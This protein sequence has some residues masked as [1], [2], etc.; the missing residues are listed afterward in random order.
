M[1]ADEAPTPEEMSPL[2]RRCSR[3]ELADGIKMTVLTVAEVGV[4]VEIE[5]AT[6]QVQQPSTESC[7]VYFQWPVRQTGWCGLPVEERP[8]LSTIWDRAEAYSLA[9]PAFFFCLGAVFTTIYFA[10]DEALQST[11]SWMRPPDMDT[12]LTLLTTFAATALL[13]V[14]GMYPIG[15]LTWYGGVSVAITRKISHIIFITLLPLT[16]V[17]LNE[18]EEG[19]ARDMYLAMVW[20]SLSSTLLL[21]I[22]FSKASRKYVPLLRIAFAGIERSDDRPHAL[23]WFSLQMVGQTLVQIPMIQW[24][25]QDERGLLI[26]IPFL[27]VG[28]GDGLAEPVGR[29]WGKHKYKVRALCSSKRYTRSF[30]GSAVVFFWTAVAV[31]IGTPD[32]TSLQ[33]VFCFLTIPLANTIMEAIS[34]HTFDN[35]FMWAVTWL[36]LWIIF[37]VIP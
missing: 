26:W 36:L 5:A 20:Q 2:S 37:D 35:H 34:P 24:M 11:L 13:L 28:L 32:M 16:V 33:A 4:T 10:A 22:L 7:C 25:L 8:D 3:E 27:S 15:L 19:L 9:I 30:E 21:A 6:V 18:Q 12:F 23:T 1:R 14:L 17:Y 31:A 29:I